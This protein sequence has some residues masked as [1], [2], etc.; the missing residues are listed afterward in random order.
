MLGDS[1]HDF[2]T[3]AAN[4][5]I[6]VEMP[7]CARPKRDKEIPPRRRPASVRRAQVFREASILVKGPTRPVVGPEPSDYRLPKISASSAIL[8]GPKLMSASAMAAQGR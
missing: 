5:K 3:V 6:T 1:A 4:R 8:P 2:A 7:S